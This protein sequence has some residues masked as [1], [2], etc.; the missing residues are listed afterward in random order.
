MHNYFYDRPDLEADRPAR[1]PPAGSRSYRTRRRRRRR[2]GMVRALACLTVFLLLMG[3]AGAGVRYAG[4]WEREIILSFGN[5]GVPPWENPALGPAPGSGSEREAQLA[6]APTG[7]GTTLQLLPE[8]ESSPLS[9]QAIYT[10]CLPSIVSIQGDSERM[11][12][13]G[14]GIIMTA[15]G[16]IITNHHVI[17]G[18]SSVSVTLMDGSASYAARLVGSD[19]STDLAVLK[20]EAQ[21]LAAA[22]FGDSALLQVGDL[23][24]AVGNPLGDQLPGTMTDGIISYIDRSVNV[25]GYDMQLIQ[26]SAALNAGN[27]GGALLNEFGQVVGVTTLKMSS[28]WNTI[29]ALGFAIPTATVKRIVDDLIAQGYVSGR[30]TIGI[31]VY[32]VEATTDGGEEEEHLAGLYVLEVDKG[33]DAWAQ[34]LR[35]GDII[36]QANGVPTPDLDDLNSQKENLKVGDSI[37]LT[38]WRDGETFPLEIRLVELSQLEG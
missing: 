13:Q 4:D 22:E 12:S 10:K 24:L 6:R 34:G 17:D 26:T 32:A 20:V 25:D 3:A 2:P 35:P 8:P 31:T 15:N 14:T 33:S 38:V 18:A 27:S 21:G 1:L 7:D 16:Y 28:D 37:S 23:A 29:E 5:A 19:V 36:L 9:S 30:P 11:T